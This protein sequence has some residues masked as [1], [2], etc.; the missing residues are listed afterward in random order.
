MVLKLLAWMAITTPFLSRI[1]FAV[2]S[3]ISP[4]RMGLSVRKALTYPNTTLD[5]STEL[6]K[7]RIMPRSPLARRCLVNS[8]MKTARAAA[9]RL[10]PDLLPITHQSSRTRLRGGARLPATLEN[11]ASSSAASF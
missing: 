9:I 1:S 4:A 7:T 10:F 5:C 6:A 3:A 8:A 2:V 11:T